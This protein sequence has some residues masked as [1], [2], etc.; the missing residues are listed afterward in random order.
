LP[1]EHLI[2]SMLI[3]PFPPLCEISPIWSHQPPSGSW[4]PASQVIFVSP[5]YLLSSCFDL[6]MT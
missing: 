6:V 2:V 4:A 1:T 3:L 5:L